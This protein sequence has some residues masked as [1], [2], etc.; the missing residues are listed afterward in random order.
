MN[1]DY[2]MMGKMRFL[3]RKIA[4]LEREI[5]KDKDELLRV[6]D[7]LL[8]EGASKQLRYRERIL[9]ARM[10][11]GEEMSCICGHRRAEREFNGP[12]ATSAAVPNTGKTM[13]HF[14]G[15]RNDRRR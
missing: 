3:R 12:S 9:E 10:D 4:P 6:K 13:D 5:E 14:R 2:G 8:F 11:R 15:Q 1:I 7:E